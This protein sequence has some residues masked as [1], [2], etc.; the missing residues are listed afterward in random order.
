MDR[1]AEE[2]A[3]RQFAIVPEG[4]DR[5]EVRTYLAELAR[6]LTASAPA[7]GLE[8][9]AHEAPA[10]DHSRWGDTSEAIAHVFEAAQA[11]AAKLVE[12]AEAVAIE[13]RANLRREAAAVR[14]DAEL[15]AAD[16][17]AQAERGAQDRIADT[18][19]QLADARLSAKAA[20]AEAERVEA[21]T[22][23]LAASIVEQAEGR[24]Q[25][26]LTEARAELERTLAVEREA[27]ARLNRVRDLVVK[28]LETSSAPGSAVD[29]PG[30]IVVLPAEPSAPTDDLSW[31]TPDARQKA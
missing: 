4:Y 3:D 19:A 31:M 24:V 1:T 14:A 21:E 17:R 23:A 16:I 30:P 18:E 20:R 8:P 13:V 29:D 12:R 10:T 22:R 27:A 6:A 26:Q 11:E 25:A 5:T 7:G 9:A 28:S 2:I 15:E